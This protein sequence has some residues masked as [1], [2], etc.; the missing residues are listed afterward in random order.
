[1]CDVFGAR[2]T[3]AILLLIGIPGMI[4]F[5]AAQN[6]PMFVAGRIIIGLSLAT[7]VTCQVWCSQFFDRSSA[8]PA[9]EREV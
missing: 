1:M 6:G 3:F 9:A 5:A 8:R 7:F 2:K 4:I